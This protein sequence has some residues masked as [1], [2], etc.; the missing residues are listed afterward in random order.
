LLFLKADVMA[1]RSSMFSPQLAWVALVAVLAF[2]A[3]AAFAIGTRSSE[4]PV[5]PPSVVESPSPS[6]LPTAS[7]T[8]Q[9]FSVL[10]RDEHGRDHPVT[11]TDESGRLVAVDPGPAYTGP[12]IG[13]AATASDPESD[14][15]LLVAW[16]FTGCSDPTSITIDATVSSVLVERQGCQGDA[17][18]GNPH[19]V[20]LTFDGPVDASSL[21]VQLV[22]TTR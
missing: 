12:E 3:V 13:D 20:T 21:D 16:A 1:P 4:Q 14:T 5:V 8:S 11:I 17:I 22:E 9:T 18:G 15:R 10:V 19:Q 7:P 6:E 2:G